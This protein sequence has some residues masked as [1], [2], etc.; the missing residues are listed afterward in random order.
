MMIVL[1]SNDCRRY[2]FYQCLIPE[3]SLNVD[4]S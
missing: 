1:F 2:Y 4:N 3:L